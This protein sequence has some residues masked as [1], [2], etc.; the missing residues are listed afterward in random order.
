MKSWDDQILLFA[1]TLRSDVLDSFFRVATWL[2]SLYVLVPTA[3][4]IAIVLLQVQKRWEAALLVIGFGAA[5]LWA[6]VAKDFFERPRPDLVDPLIPLPS[7]ASMPS[8]H[9]AQIAAFSLCM[10]LIIR[11]T[12][13][14]WQFHT[15]II[16]SVVSTVV[17][18]SR[19]YLQVHFPSDVLA[20]ALFA[21][22]WVALIQKLL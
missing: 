1:A 18:I 12:L 10:V 9:T 3:V 11:R 22:L 2:G 21:I 5:S 16:A 6:H 7:D 8:A 15:I 13:P 17:A 14:E 19:V 4:L 20:G